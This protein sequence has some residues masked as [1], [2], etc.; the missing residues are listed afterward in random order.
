M[1]R[2]PWDP[3]VAVLPRVVLF[4]LVTVVIWGSSEIRERV[5][6]QPRFRLGTWTLEFGEFPSWV[7]PTIRAEIE[8]VRD[9]VL[10]RDVTVFDR[11]VLASVR[12][13]LLANPWIDSVASIG[14]RYPGIDDNGAARSGG[15]MAEL[16]LRRPIASV[17]WAARLYLTDAAGRRLGAPIETVA[18]RPGVPVIVGAVPAMGASPPPPGSQWKRRDLLEGLAVARELF[19]AGLTPHIDEIDVRNVGSAHPLD[20]EIMLHVRRYPPL[21]W[22]RSPISRGARVLPTEEKIENLLRIL[23]CDPRRFERFTL[24]RLFA[25]NLASDRVIAPAE[26]VPPDDAN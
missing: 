16:V 25:A 3:R 10:L 18:H 24:I 12:E 13:Q 4:V 21:A 1:T 26:S 20:P 15:L 17:D 8:E 9:R 7:S 2:S 19:N 11:G 5:E 6:R 23:A 14:L 22:G